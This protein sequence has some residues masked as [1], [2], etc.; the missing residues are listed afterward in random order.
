MSAPFPSDVHIIETAFDPDEEL[1]LFRQRHQTAGAIASFVG[2]VRDEGGQVKSLT[3]EHYP[4]FAEKTI[5]QFVSMALARFALS[6]LRIIH[7]SGPLAPGDPIV[8]VATAAA[9]RR[10]AIDA[11]DFLMDYLKTEAPF[12]KREE[13]ADGSQWIEPRQEDRADRN[14]WDA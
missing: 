12:W 7:R 5:K 10:A 3:L 13:T 6:G 4:G 9:H 2:Q 11:V 8:L 1:R 14:R